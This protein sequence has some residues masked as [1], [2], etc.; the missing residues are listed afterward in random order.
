MYLRYT[1][2]K[3][4]I[5]F[6]RLIVSPFAG[7]SSAKKF[8]DESKITGVLN[9]NYERSYFEILREVVSMSCIRVS[10]CQPIRHRLPGEKDKL[11]SCIS[12]A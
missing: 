1:F 10:A 3:A 8:S 6:C 9:F 5:R 4:N 11:Q 12:A 2:S 7:F